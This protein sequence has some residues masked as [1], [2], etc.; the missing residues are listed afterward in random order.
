MKTEKEV[1]TVK[2]MI[3]MLLGFPVTLKRTKYRTRTS[4]LRTVIAPKIEGKGPDQEELKVLISG[5]TAVPGTKVGVHFEPMFTIDIFFPNTMFWLE[6]QEKVL[7]LGRDKEQ[8]PQEE[9]KKEEPRDEAENTTPGAEEEKVENTNPKVDVDEEGDSKEEAETPRVNL[10]EELHEKVVKFIDSI[11]NLSN[12]LLYVPGP[13]LFVK[14]GIAN[15][16]KVLI[17]QFLEYTF[18]F[19]EE[20]KK[21]N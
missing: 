11:P 14:E 5:L 4:N 8:F 16:L 3:E 19:P 13:G 10:R 15:A 18:K 6:Y 21:S 2:D 7:E 20:K 12:W 17:D 1:K 9:E